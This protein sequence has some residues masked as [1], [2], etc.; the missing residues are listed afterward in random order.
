M[1]IS[2]SE[3]EVMKIIWGKKGE[4]VTTAYILDSLKTP[5]KHTTVL[6]FLKR[7]CD[8]GVLRCERIGK[9]NLYSPLISEREYK[10]AQTKE[11]MS[12]LHSGS[13]KNFLTAL[14]GDKRPTKDEI[15]EIKEWFEGV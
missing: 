14:Y 9:A 11:F 1:K 4:A 10:N 5:W 3:M 6:T 12:E 2:E 15:N 8:K 13:V 7:L